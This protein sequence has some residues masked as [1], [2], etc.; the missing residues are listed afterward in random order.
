MAGPAQHVLLVGGRGTRLGAITADRPKPMVD[1]AG[2]PFVEHLMDRAVACGARHIVLLCGYL[3][4]DFR[5][6]YHGLDWAGA[7]VECVD[8][9]EPLGTG[10]ALVHAAHHLAPNFWLVNGDSL[11][12]FDR[13]GFAAWR[14]GGRWLVKMALAH[15]PDTSAS[16]AVEC[17]P[18]GRV[19]RFLERGPA[20][21]GY[22][23]AGVYLVDRAILDHIGTSPCSL[24]SEIFPRL[25]EKSLLW[26]KP[27]GGY[28]VDIGTPANLER[29][30]H[31][32]KTE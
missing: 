17:P 27:Y 19:T 21:S 11:F 1:V 18:D 4:A 3:A 26:A 14:P 24:E 12:E 6:R 32:I 28:F 16:G 9:S 30:R 22:I 29:A 5:D 10:G 8:E 23:N 31:D 7:K 13:D 25:V 2:R 20:T 15:C